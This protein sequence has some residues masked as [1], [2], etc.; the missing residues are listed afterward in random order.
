LPRIRATLIAAVALREGDRLNP[1]PVAEGPGR[2]GYRMT[3]AQVQFGEWVRWLGRLDAAATLPVYQKFAASPS[4]NLRAA[5]YR[6]LLKQGDAAA[7]AALERDLPA[8]APTMM[9]R[10]V[11]DEAN[12]QMLARDPASLHVMGRILIAEEALPAFEMRAPEYLGYTRNREVLPYLAAM[13]DHPDRDQRTSV[14]MDICTLLDARRDPELA[15]QCPDRSPLRDPPEEPRL[16][17][18][19][20]EWWAGQPDAKGAVRPPGRYRGAGAPP[21]ERVISMEQRFSM[22]AMMYAGAEKRRKQDPSQPEWPVVPEAKLSAEDAEIAKRIFL[23]V[24]RAQDEFQSAV[25]ALKQNLRMQSKP[26]DGAAF[27]Q[28]ATAQEGT[29]RQALDQLRRE[30]SREGWAAAEKFMKEMNIH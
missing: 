16:V 6:G 1:E 14:I 11:G 19:W 27:G 18:F 26:W 29:M 25:V 30:L 24:G 8:I 23:A 21:A 9:A 2:T 28:L 13:L 3:Q 5:G 10:L 22:M 4:A 17:Q 7:L 20:K 12:L 15:R